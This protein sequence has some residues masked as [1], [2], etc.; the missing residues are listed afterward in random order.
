[1][2]TRLLIVRHGQTDWNI[3]RR[4][5][6]QTDIPL[7]SEGITQAQAIARHLTHEKL[8]TIYSSN[9]QRAWQTAEIIQQALSRDRQ[10]PLIAEPRLRE[11]CFGEWEGLRYEEIQARQPQQLRRWETDLENTAPPGGE[12]LLVVAER[13]QEAFK[14]L[15]LAHPDGSVLLVGHGGSLQLLIAQALGIS[16]RNFWQIHLSNASLSELQL[17]PDGAILMLLNCTNHLKDKKWES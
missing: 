10:P 14:T 7:N 17:Y 5:Q 13:V 12:T 2:S 8:A 3:D 15:A 6:G 4:F 1:M 11:M 16:P 9:L